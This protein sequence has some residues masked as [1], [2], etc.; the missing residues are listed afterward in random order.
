M[1]A[2]EQLKNVYGEKRYGSKTWQNYEE[3]IKP[4]LFKTYLSHDNFFE[5]IK[6][7]KEDEKDE[8]LINSQKAIQE[9]NDKFLKLYTES[10]IDLKKSSL[11]NGWNYKRNEVLRE[12]KNKLEYYYIV[13]YHFMFN[14]KKKESFCNWILIIISSISTIMTFF[15]YDID[16]FIIKIISNVMALLTALLAAYIN[17]EKFV[18]R[19][20]EIDRYI[21]KVGKTS[22]ELHYIINSKVWNRISYESFIDKYKN[23]ILMLFSYPPPLSPYDFKNTVFLLTVYYPELISNTYPWY[24]VEKIGDIEYY[25]MTPWGREIIDSY[26]NY[27]KCFCKRMYKNSR[28]INYHDYNRRTL[29]MTEIENMKKNKKNFHSENYDSLSNSDTEISND[30]IIDLEEGIEKTVEG[31]II[32]KESS[33]EIREEIKE[34][35]EKGIEEDI[36]IKKDDEK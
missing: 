31:G 22:R 4:M 24:V 20:K 10:Y 1:N 21:Q 36:D 6:K 28:F 2:D 7:T 35:I 13:N 11:I 12:W 34:N 30:I 19:I 18:D 5:N 25:K 29:H 27:K 3:K 32:K 8:D 9:L 16:A 26:S 23:D 17:N 14:L 33:E 15:S